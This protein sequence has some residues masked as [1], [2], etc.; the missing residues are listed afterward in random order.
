[1]VSPHCPLHLLLF[2]PPLLLSPIPSTYYSPIFTSASRN[3]KMDEAME[4]LPKQKKNAEVW[5]GG[6]GGSRPPFGFAFGKPTGLFWETVFLDKTFLLQVSLVLA[7]LY[8][9]IRRAQNSRHYTLS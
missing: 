4:R 7:G 1:V 8:P 9:H 5:P 6:N 2:S 3:P